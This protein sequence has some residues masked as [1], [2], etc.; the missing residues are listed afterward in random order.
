MLLTDFLL[1]IY[2]P[3]VSPDDGRAVRAIRAAEKALEQPMCFGIGTSG[4]AIRIDDRD[5]WVPAQIKV[6]GRIPL[7]CNGDKEHFVSI[8]SSAG[9]SKLRVHLAMPPDLGNSARATAAL[10]GMAEALLAHWATLDPPEARDMV[11]DQMIHPGKTTNPPPGLPELT[12]PQY[13]NAPPEEP[14]WLGWQNYWSEQAAAMMGVKESSRDLNVFTTAEHLAGGGWLLRVTDQ[15]LDPKRP[16]HMARLAAAYNRF[17][18]LGR[19]NR[20]EA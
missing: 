2:C 11:A 16:E 5:S 7:V 4:E 14:P 15:P 19:P 20:A 10:H 17:P 12:P 1:E 13:G 9:L 18:K 6:L 8:R 3:L